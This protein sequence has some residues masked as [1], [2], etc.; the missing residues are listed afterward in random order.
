MPLIL[1]AF[2]SG[3]APRPGSAPGGAEVTRISGGSIRTPISQSQVLNE[4]SSVRRDWIAVKHADLPVQIRDTPGLKVAAESRRGRPPG[5]VYTASLDVQATQSIA[6]IEVRFLTFNIW[7]LHER[8]LILTEIKDFPLGGTKLEGIW[9]ARSARQAGEFHTSIVYISRV[10]T[11]D[12]KVFVADPQP[13]IDEARKLDPNFTAVDLDPRLP[14][15]PD[16]D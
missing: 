4:G 10:R 16:D 13:V 3:F 11:M 8:T 12:G 2:A 15:T 14:E 6:A 1:L 9:N 7:G 5:F